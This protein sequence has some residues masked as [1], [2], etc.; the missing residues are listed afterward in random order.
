M[1]NLQRIR[2]EKGLTQTELAR[3]SGVPLK[4]LLKYE[5]EEIKIERASAGAVYR[6]AV[7]LECNMEDLI[8]VKL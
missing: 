3:I 4:S 5:Q 8:D 2:K 1:N 6:L 7:A